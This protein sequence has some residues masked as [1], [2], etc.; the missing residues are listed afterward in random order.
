MVLG[1]NFRRYWC[2]CDI[3]QSY[4]LMELLDNDDCDRDTTMQPVEQLGT[5]VVAEGVLVV[6]EEVLL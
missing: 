2:T 5:L 6:L 4:N 1:N 3:E